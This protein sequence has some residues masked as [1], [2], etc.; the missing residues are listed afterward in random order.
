MGL[1]GLLVHQVM[2]G[3]LR[4]LAAEPSWRLLLSSVGW[5]EAEVKLSFE[6][7][8]Y[9]L[10]PSRRALLPVVFTG[11]GGGRNH[12]GDCQHG[13]E[14]ADAGPQPCSRGLQQPPGVQQERFPPGAVLP[15][16]LT[17]KCK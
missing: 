1:F 16:P 9:G 5:V 2:A 4:A 11:W 7:M 3:M 10:R 15:R 17:F 14:V 8:D 13:A 12:L 6:P